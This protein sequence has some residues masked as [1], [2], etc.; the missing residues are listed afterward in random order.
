MGVSKSS[1]AAF[2]LKRG[3]RSI[4]IIFVLIF[5]SFMLINIAPGD[6]INFI[7]G[8]VGQ[9]TEEYLNS[10]RESFGLNKPLYTRFF[11]YIFNLFKGNPGYSYIYG[12]PV[13]DLIKA[14]ILPTL[15]LMGMNIF[16]IIVVGVP[17]GILASRK[18]F[19]KLDTFICVFSLI[20]ISI[21]VFLAGLLSVQLFSIKL[22]LFPAQG[23]YSLRR[24]GAL[25]L[26]DLLH[27]LVL[28]V[29]SLSL[30]NMGLIVRITRT[31]MLEVLR[32]E[33]IILAKSKG[34]PERILLFKHAF[35]N[36]VL[37]ILTLIGLQIGWLF[38]GAVLTETIFAWPGL[39][40]LLFLS[41]TSRDYPTIMGI[42][43]LISIG[44]IFSNLVV[45]ILYAI[46]DPRIRGI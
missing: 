26:L 7:V 11:L 35:K 12:V 21:P 8:D 19:S 46:I 28:P 5:L 9:Y 20:G 13:I 16:V 38:G 27:H 17:L 24:E 43:L 30:V 36:A 18:P 10:I 33:Y 6:P 42:F 1:F 34:V 29:L 44:V 32:S 2:L 45:D 41:I 39:G 14:R 25:N 31:S 37:P 40:T 4:L 23:M 15:L 22:N 3:I